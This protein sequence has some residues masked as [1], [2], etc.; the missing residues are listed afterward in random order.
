MPFSFGGPAQFHA[1]KDEFSMRAMQ[2]SAMNVG[3]KVLATEKVIHALPVNPDE[4]PQRVCDSKKFELAWERF[5]SSR[6]PFRE[7][8]SGAYNL[9]PPPSPRHLLPLS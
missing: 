1:S 8:G 4:V 9:R 3:E 7:G 2:T 5:N 6:E